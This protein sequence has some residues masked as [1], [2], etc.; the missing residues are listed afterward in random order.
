[1]CVIT[2]GVARAFPGGR[3]AHPEGQNEEETKSSLRKNKKNWS[4]FEEKI[5]KVELLPTRDCEAGY[6]P[7]NN[8]SQL[9]KMKKSRPTFLTCLS[10]KNY[11][12]EAVGL[13]S[14]I[15]TWKVMIFAKMWNFE[16]FCENLIFCQ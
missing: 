13:K 2:S 10:H 6:G 8:G 11:R 12:V 16:Q 5:R 3:V 9:A 7:G 14:S 1:M 15:Y 4:K